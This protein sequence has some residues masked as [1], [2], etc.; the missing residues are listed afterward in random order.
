MQSSE[1][2][3]YFAATATTVSF[4]PQ[5]IKVIRTRDTRSISLA[6]Y[7]L[8]SLGLVLWLVYGIMLNA[9]PVILA[10]A[11]TLCFA[12][13]ILGYKLRERRGC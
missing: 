12:V 2:L 1:L 7:V 3:G 9:L 11:V 13:V 8:F 6:M 10:N 4:L 5:T